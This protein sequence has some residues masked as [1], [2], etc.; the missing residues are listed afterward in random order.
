MR[1]FFQTF[2]LLRRLDPIIGLVFCEIRQFIGLVFCEIRQFIGL[3]FVF[4]AVLSLEITSTSSILKHVILLNCRISHVYRK[5]N[6]PSIAR[7]ASFTV[8]KAF[9]HQRSSASGEINSGEELGEA[10]RLFY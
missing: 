1:S 3:V 2:G 9:A 5:K 8:K 10:V 7:L 6:R 4:L